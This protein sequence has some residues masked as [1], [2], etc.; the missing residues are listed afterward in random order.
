[1]PR[2]TTNGIEIEYETF[3]DA[4]ARP[5]LLITGLGAQMI[6]WPK[7]FCESLAADG[8]F[9]IRFDNRDIGLSSKLEAAG[10]PDQGEMVRRALAGEPVEAPY[11][12]S[13]MADD[14]AGLLDALSVNQAHVCGASLGG[15]IALVFASAYP[16]RTRSL[17][18]IMATAEVLG[19]A[20]PDP[21]AAEFLGRPAPDS[22]ADYLEH[23]VELSRVLSGT[24][25]PFDEARTRQS[26]SESLERSRY[27]AGMARQAAAAAARG[28]KLD[29]VRGITTPTLSL[30]GSDDPLVPV[31]WGRAAAAAI[32][33]ARFLA[34]EGMGHELP[35]GAW[36]QIVEAISEHTKAAEA[37]SRG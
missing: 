11:N 7:E 5:L 1:M 17:I 24:G 34:I 30:H 19:I 28:M 15:A 2:A 14:V 36:P 25:F 6:W 12:I 8:H 27:P 4:S 26:V 20:Q 23:M 9:V 33:N 29:D 21:T 22:R 32:P 10:V 3:G 35:E 16:E 18:P 31:E 37:A 13:D